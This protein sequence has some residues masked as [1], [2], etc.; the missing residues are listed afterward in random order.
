[1]IIKKMFVV[2]KCHNNSEVLL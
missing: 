1:M 2:K